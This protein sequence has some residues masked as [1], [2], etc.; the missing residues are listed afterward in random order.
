SF[1]LFS[2]LSDR[3]YCFDCG[4]G[5]RRWEPYDDPWVEHAKFSPD[6][7]FLRL[8]KGE[9]FIQAFRNPRSATASR[10]A[11][12]DELEE[13]EIRDGDQPRRPRQPQPPPPPPPPPAQEPMPLPRDFPREAAEE[14][15]FLREER[16]CKVCLD[17]KV[18][19]VFLPCGHLS[20]CVSCAVSVDT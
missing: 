20:T 19:V 14:L 17:H 11:A 10:P 5:V 4:E 3:V 6:C 13:G 18:E 12:D 7:S 16:K 2:G 9:I 8:V 15:E 1:S